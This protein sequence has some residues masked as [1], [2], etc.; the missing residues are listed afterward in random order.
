VTHGKLHKKGKIV[1]I[2]PA[3]GSDKWPPAQVAS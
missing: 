2:P 3:H 1:I